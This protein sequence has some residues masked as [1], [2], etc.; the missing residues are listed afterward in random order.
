MVKPIAVIK[1][2][3]RINAMD[4]I[5]NFHLIENG[6]HHIQF[7]MLRDKTSFF[8]IA[9]ESHLILYRSMIEVLKGTS[10]LSVTGRPS[11]NRSY[12]YKL[13]NNTWQEI[14]K[15]EIDGCEKAWRF[16]EPTPCQEPKKLREF[17]NKK[18]QKNDNNF[19]IGFY[20][21]LSM[22]Q[23]ECFMEKYIEKRGHYVTSLVML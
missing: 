2:K 7:E 11:K 3:I 23:T 8:R 17:G 19:L 14:H 12:K 9:R 1:E 5:D 4:K 13:G 20:D 15:V 18:N 21:A 22:I 16:S 10:N 6:L